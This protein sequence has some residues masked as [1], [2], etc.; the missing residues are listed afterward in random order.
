M[1]LSEELQEKWAPVLDLEGE[2]PIT[3]PYKRAV[4]AVILENQE[5][6]LMEDAPVNSGF[7]GAGTLDKYDPILISLVRRSLPNLM[8]YDVCGVQPMTGPTGLIF[9][10]K[11]RYTNQT[12]AEALF[13]EAD[14]G[15]SNAGAGSQ[16]GSNPVSGTYTVAPGMT[17][18]TAESLAST[19]G[20]PGQPFA[21]MAFTIEKT[22]VTADS[23][24]LAAGYT[25]ELAQDLKAIHGLDAEG[26]LS[27]ILSQEIL[28]EINREII[29]R[30]YVV[31]KPGA[32]STNTPGT[33]D[34]D[35]DSNGRWSVER[36]KGL[37]FQVERDANV[38]AQETRRGRGNVL[39]CS[40]DVASAFAM[41]GKLDYG[42][43]LRGNDGISSDDTGNTYAGILNGKYKVFID[44]YS[45][46]INAASQFYVVGYKGP[47]AYDAGLFYCPYVP[48]QMVRAVDPKTF[49]P[50]IGFK[51]RYGVIANPFVMQANG[52]TDGTTFTANR[53]HYFRRVQVLNLL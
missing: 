23:R 6:A 18:A 19:T 26:E 45:A 42:T 37:M 52:V 13:N 38:I 41:A 33:F 28:A 24:A 8:A 30:I 34:L 49:Q 1:Y 21:E 44:P 25:V 32:A 43:G 27:N 14:A 7:G 20:T 51:T 46:N 48:L 3:S 47:N 36:F 22:S 29:R 40:S 12:G 39:I 17:T 31:A 9:A 35:I 50:R 10:M 53:N 15:F 16:T 5:K 2:V 4:T 11:S